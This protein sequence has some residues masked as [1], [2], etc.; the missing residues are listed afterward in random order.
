MKK[1]IYKMSSLCNKWLGKGMTKL[2]CRFTVT[3]FITVTA[4]NSA[5][6]LCYLSPS[7]TFNKPALVL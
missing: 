4:T 6:L 1:H 5:T 2:G 7:W 3:K